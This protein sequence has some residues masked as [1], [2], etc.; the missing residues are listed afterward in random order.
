MPRST[1]STP[2]SS[3][4]SLTNRQ[5]PFALESGL[6]EIT[7]TYT[8]PPLSSLLSLRLFPNRELTATGNTLRSDRWGCS[9]LHAFL[10]LR[11]AMSRFSMY[12]HPY[13]ANTYHETLPNNGMVFRERVERLL[14]PAESSAFVSASN[15]RT[16]EGE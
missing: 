16:K 13:D 15:L 14:G 9:G 11:D 3:L 12:I 7:T 10:W 5:E 8:R 6:F 4:K 2:I 1:S